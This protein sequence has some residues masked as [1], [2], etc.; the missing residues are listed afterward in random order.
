MALVNIGANSINVNYPEK[1]VT[2]FTC[3]YHNRWKSIPPKKFK[4]S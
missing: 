1:G 2:A 4:N 3:G